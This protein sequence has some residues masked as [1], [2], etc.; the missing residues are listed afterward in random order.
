MNLGIH[1]N[2]KGKSREQLPGCLICESKCIACLPCFSSNCF[3]THFP[4]PRLV[5][6]PIFFLT[7]AMHFSCSWSRMECVL[8]STMTKL[9]YWDPN[10][11]RVDLCCIIYYNLLQCAR[12]T[13]LVTSGLFPWPPKNQCSKVS[14]TCCHMVS[15]FHV[16]FIAISQVSKGSRRAC[17][18]TLVSMW[19]RFMSRFPKWSA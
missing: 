4:S 10:L 9:I 19:M 17:V 1:F 11:C 8:W 3:K 12:P 7:R 16:F 5:A 6:S 15:K 14:T 2:S 18:S 13:I